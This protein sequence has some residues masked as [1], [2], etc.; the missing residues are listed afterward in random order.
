MLIG[1]PDGAMHLHR[2]FKHRQGR[3]ADPRLSSQGEP[4]G[5]LLAPVGHAG[6]LE[7]E[8]AIGFD[9]D[10]IVHRAM[11]H[12]LE[13]A[14]RAAELLAG[15][16]IVQGHGLGRFHD[17]QQ[18]GGQAQLK[19]D[20]EAF[21]ECRRRRTPGQNATGRDGDAIKFEGAKHGS[22]DGPLF[23][24][25]QTRRLAVHIKQNLVIAMPG[26]EDEPPRRDGRWDRRQTAPQ[27][28]RAPV[29]QTKRDPRIIAVQRIALE[30]G[31]NQGLA[32]ERLFHEPIMRAAFGRGQGHYAHR[33]RYDGQGGKGCAQ[34]LGDQ[35]E[36]GRALPRAA[37]VLGRD[38]SKPALLPGRRES[39]G[40]DR[41]PFVA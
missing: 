7:N 12:G 1:E 18:P 21:P 13:L 6:G 9:V 36:L 34:F 29:A 38:Q 5:H 2:G 23:V 24:D 37:P 22:V 10:V 20:V 11:L 3:L 19:H 35:A 41:R 39:P 17:P 33:R 4:V 26:I 31:D 15:H 27:D 16:D 40:V 32:G 30:G 8:G 28:D 25:R 14:D